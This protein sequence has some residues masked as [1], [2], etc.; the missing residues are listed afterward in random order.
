LLLI[1]PAVEKSA[2]QGFAR[3]GVERG[4]R[5]IHEQYLGGE[6]PG[7]CQGDALAQA[8]RELA[9]IV[10]LVGA[11]P[12]HLKILVRQAPALRAGDAAQFEAVFDIALGR[13]PRQQG[14]TG[15]H[16]ADLLARG[17][18]VGAEHLHIAAARLNKTSTI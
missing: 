6:C 2:M 10:A 8:L 3:L 17:A 5:L 1:L 11:E 18:R 12:D 15:E 13:S 16:V 4:E 7:A 14:E 9:G